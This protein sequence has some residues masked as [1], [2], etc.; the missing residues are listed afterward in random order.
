MQD[1]EGRPS[2]IGGVDVLKAAGMVS[3]LP[4]SRAAKTRLVED[5]AVEKL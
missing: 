1:I 5:P 2:M 4:Q 3:G